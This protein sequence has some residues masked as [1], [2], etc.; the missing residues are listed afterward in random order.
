MLINLGQI[1]LDFDEVQEIDLNPVLLD[2]A[3]PV[4]VD[5]LIVLA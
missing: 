2:G 4:V 5:A 1:G 3:R